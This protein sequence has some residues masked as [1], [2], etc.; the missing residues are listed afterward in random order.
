MVKKENIVYSAEVLEFVRL[1]KEYCT[2][3][4]TPLK[5]ESQ[6]FIRFSLY[7]LP[8]LYSSMIRIPEVDTVFDE[9]VEK[10]VTEAQWA[11]VYRKVEAL[12]GMNN[13]Y[14]DIPDEKEFDRS[15]LVTRKISEDMADIYQ[16]LRDFLEVFRNSPEEIMND[17]LWE[18]QN[19]FLNS[20]GTKTLR[21]ATAL[22]RVYSGEPVSGRLLNQKPPHSSGIDTR[23]WFISRSQEDYTDETDDLFTEH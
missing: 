16:D 8:A 1:A 17:A 4:E 11:D 18:C 9:G 14:L 21:V 2:L 15:E 20:W 6:I 10:F 3:M 19:T 13:D 23:N 7:S 22:N 5:L 12:A